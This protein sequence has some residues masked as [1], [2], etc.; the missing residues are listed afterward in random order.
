M[1]RGSA[2]RASRGRPSLEATCSSVILFGDAARLRK[3]AMSASHEFKAGDIVLAKIKG[4]P[5]WPGIL[6]DDANVPSAVR[7]ERPSAK[8]APY[9][10]R[11]FPAADYHWSSA[12]DLK[13]LTP[14]DID[15]F[16]ANPKHKGQLREAYVL[17]KDPHEWNAKQ[18]KIVEEHEAWV[19]E[20]GNEED[21][22]DEDEEKEGDD[23]GQED[24][25]DEEDEDEAPA[26]KRSSKSTRSQP[27]K[28][29]RSSSTAKGA[30]STTEPAAPA[31]KEGDADAEHEAEEE[32]DPATRRVREWRH[33]LQ[34]AFLSK[35]GVIV[36][37]DMDAQDATFKTVEAYTDMT[38]DQLKA[39]K[40]GKVMKRI[41]HLPEIPRDDEFKFRQRAGD[42][43]KR[44]GALIDA[45][46]AAQAD[47]ADVAAAVETP[48]PGASEA[49]AVEHPVEKA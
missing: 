44:W 4:Y 43:M 46:P 15:A 39:T 9:T 18:N 26:K 12:R 13:P 28:R 22:D 40:I 31:G 24:K 33:K 23:D 30:N 7:E 14:H 48:A 10:V 11:F 32:L 5:A 36:A 29:A 1:R 17:A 35:G 21:E 41:H 20:H 45:Q 3:C 49:A 19:A 6:M 8:A 16:L 42:L 47:G 34:R 37:S 25:D 38:V 2:P 27:S